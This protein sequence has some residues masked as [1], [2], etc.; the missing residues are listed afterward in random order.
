MTERFQQDLEGLTV[1]DGDRPVTSY[2]RVLKRLGV[3]AE[4]EYIQRKVVQAWIDEGHEMAEPLVLSLEA[5]GFRFPIA[6]GARRR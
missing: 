6:P 3:V 5:A 4:P 1:G 2:R